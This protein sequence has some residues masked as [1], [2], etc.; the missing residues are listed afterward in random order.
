MPIKY[1][2][3][4]FHGDVSSMPDR[5]RG[6]SDEVYL[7]GIGF[8]QYAYFHGGAA[9]NEVSGLLIGICQGDL[10]SILSFSN[11][12]RRAR[13]LYNAFL[14]RG[15]G[16]GGSCTWSGCHRGQFLAISPNALERIF[17]RPLSQIHIEP[18]LCDSSERMRV[19]H[20]LASLSVAYSGSRSIDPLFVES[21]ALAAMR[22]CGAGPKEKARKTPA[23]TVA[24][25]DLLR[26][27]IEANLANPLS[28]RQLAGTV[29]L[30]ES[31]F[32]RAFKGSFGMTPY[33]YVLRQRVALAQTLLE[34]GDRSLAEVAGPSGFHD[35]NRM[36]RT[37]RQITGRSPS[38]F[39]KAKRRS[40]SG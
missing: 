14:L 20:L 9:T 2:R 7:R 5:L 23:L 1:S 24:Q 31:Y 4:G 6:L 8:L 29:N 27:V 22:A 3:C 37:F 39:S 25:I 28:V 32:V 13:G 15:P 12:D 21:V 11:S 38:G 34:S 17:G 35:A 10:R 33:K 19:W 40:K 30:S 18:V 16:Q 36:G 26:D